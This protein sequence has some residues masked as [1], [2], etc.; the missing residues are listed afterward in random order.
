[1]ATFTSLLL[2]MLR[3]NFLFYIQFF[4]YLSNNYFSSKRK[5]LGS[6][7]LLELLSRFNFSRR[8]KHNKIWHSRTVKHNVVL[9]ILQKQKAIYKSWKLK[10]FLQNDLVRMLH[11]FYR[12]TE[13]KAT[14]NMASFRCRKYSQYQIII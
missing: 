4:Q 11:I 2:F 5:K 14:K 3:L 6:L 12:D 10:K 9:E 1:M 8:K 7:R 13:P